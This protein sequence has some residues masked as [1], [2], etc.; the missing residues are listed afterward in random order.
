[1]IKLLL[2]FDTESLELELADA[3]IT[4]G[5][6]SENAIALSDKKT[7]RKHAR[8]EKTDQGYRLS[9]LGSGNG[10][11]VNGRDVESVLLTKGDEV[12]IGLTTLYVLDFDGPVPAPAPVAVPVAVE[13]SAPSAVPPPA[14]VVPPS[15]RVEAPAPVPAAPAATTENARP[16]ITRRSA[17]VP[18][19]SAGGKV[20]AA[21]LTLIILGSVAY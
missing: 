10:T 20:V 1:M 9:D 12:K 6:S 2:R 18:R 21:A 14:P 15:P 11:R 17:Y 5:R 3:S 13:V 7:S 4:I 19:G 16:K 8:I